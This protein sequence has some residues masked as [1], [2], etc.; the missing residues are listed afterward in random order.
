MT[1]IESDRP[2]ASVSSEAVVRSNATA[3]MAAGAIAAIAWAG[4]LVLGRLG[5]PG[6]SQGIGGAATLLLAIVVGGSFLV[7]PVLGGFAGGRAS[8]RWKAVLGSIAGTVGATLA[9]QLVVVWRSLDRQSPGA[10][11]LTVAYV[12]ILATLGHLFATRHDTS[13]SP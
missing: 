13:G 1:A 10:V 5:F 7:I 6:P 9:A 8:R 4:I 3:A 2:G 11:L 12:A